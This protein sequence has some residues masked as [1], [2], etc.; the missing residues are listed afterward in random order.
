MLTN[1]GRPA[2]PQVTERYREIL[3]G[4]SPAAAADADA[5]ADDAP[6]DDAPLRP[7]ISFAE[8]KKK[9]E[10]EDATHIREMEEN[11]R[12]MKRSCAA[13]DEQ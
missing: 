7:L 2:P 11:G 10:E 13:G 6:A 3:G 12:R 8:W 9:R 5:P 4:A 1:C